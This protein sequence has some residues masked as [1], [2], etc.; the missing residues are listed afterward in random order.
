MRYERGSEVS[1][2]SGPRSFV[3]SDECLAPRALLRGLVMVGRRGWRAWVWASVLTT[4]GL[5]DASA[6]AEPEPAPAES[7]PAPAPAESAPAEGYEDERT[8]KVLRELGRTVAK[9]AEGKKIGEIVVVR[10]DVFVEDEVWPTFLNGLHWTTQDGI[11][12]RELLF[13]VGEPYQQARIDESARKLRDQVIFAFVR[14]VPVVP[15]SGK[16]DEVDVLVFTRDLWSLRLES[17]F[18]LTGSVI[19]NLALTLI[20]RNLLGRNYQAALSFDLDPGTW[21]VGELFVDRRLFGSRWQFSES[22]ELVFGRMGSTAGDLEGTRGSVGV[23]LP[24]WDLRPRYGVEASA[25]WNVTTRRQLSGDSLLT[26]DDAATPE[27]EA[28]PRVWDQS[29]VKLAL[30]GVRQMGDGSGG[31][32]VH[33]FY[34]GYGAY[35]TD[36]TPNVDTGLAA[37]SP[38]RARFVDEVLPPSRRQLYPYFR[39]QSFTPHWANFRD[40]AAFGLTEDVRT[41][42]WIDL[43]FAAPLVAF[44]SAKDALTLEASAGLVLAP[45]LGG[46]RALFDLRAGMYARV[47]GG[48]LID[49]DYSVRFRTAS[50]RFVLGRVIASIDLVSRVA[51]SGRTLVSVGGDNGLRG[52]ASQAFYGFGVDRLRANVEL[53]TPPVV[54]GSVHIGGVLFYDAGGVGDGPASLDLHHALGLGLRMLLPQFNRF[55]F[56]LDLG[57]PLDHG[58]AERP[59]LLFSLGSTQAVPLTTLEDDKLSQ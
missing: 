7:A 53:R 21:A 23:G 12:R 38:E 49:Q 5:F 46:D 41:G 20:E 45:E 52:F 30:Q 51:D 11:V 34:F 9:D 50:P 28:V 54:L 44:G 14:I 16:A 42:P 58:G 6:R 59:A 29:L 36:Y 47:E 35:L 26:W 3:G 17:A 43:A 18:G 2:T 48:A 13:E 4:W 31:S 1:A 55:A 24:L 19:D 56:R 33:R 40:L 32:W 57:F 10:H 8:A 22:F 39:W 37:D 27:T 25:A 15:T